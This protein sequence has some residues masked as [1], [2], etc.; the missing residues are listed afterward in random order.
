MVLYA[1]I[2]ASHEE[3]LYE[4][5]ILRT[6]GA[7]RRQVLL[8]LG[9]EFITLGILAGILATLTA[10]GIA[11][12]LAESIFELPYHF[13]IWI[14]VIGVI[15]GGIGIGLAGILGTYSILQQPPSAILQKGGS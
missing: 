11:Y 5:A 4:G 15:G 9:A 3:R 12:V 13:N 2:A 10:S 6:L 14:G 8:G 1:A 7:T